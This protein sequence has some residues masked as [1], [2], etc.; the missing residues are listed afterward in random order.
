MLCVGNGC[1]KLQTYRRVI[2]A[3]C[4]E[5]LQDA[6]DLEKDDECCV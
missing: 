3:V 4:R 5:W 1:R 2:S 6:T